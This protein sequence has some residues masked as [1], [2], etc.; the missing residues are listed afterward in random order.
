M[1][2][3]RQSIWIRKRIEIFH[4]DWNLEINNGFFG[5]NYIIIVKMN[6]EIPTEEI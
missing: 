6:S 3:A 1:N 5:Y 4:Y 2:T